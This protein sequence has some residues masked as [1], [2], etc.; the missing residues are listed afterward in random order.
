MAATGVVALKLV[1][2]LGRRVERPLQKICADQRR[3][4]VHFVE[5]LDLLRNVDVG[6]GVVQ[7]LRH[8]LLTEY[9]R[10]LLGC[11][12]LMGRRIEQRRR[13]VFHVRADII[14]FCG[15]LALVKVGFVGDFVLFHGSFSFEMIFC[16]RQKNCPDNNMPGQEISCGATLLDAKRV[17]S[18]RT[19]MR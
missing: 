12:G 17:L 14:P 13:L 3:R 2:D 5:V 7:L 16:R 11:H 9:G 1:I 6:V 15:D 4:T 18:T 19:D 8:Q 10:K